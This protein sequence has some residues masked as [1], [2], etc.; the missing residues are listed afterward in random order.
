MSVI[1]LDVDG[2]VINEAKNMNI[3]TVTITQS[4]IEYMQR[5]SCNISRLFNCVES[6][7][8]RGC[9]RF[10]R[11]SLIKKSKFLE[12]LFGIIYSKRGFALKKIFFKKIN[13]NPNKPTVYY[14][15]SSAFWHDELILNLRII[16]E[17]LVKIK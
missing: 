11:F 5:L 8:E 17:S 14:P 1:S 2:K 13:L 15:L 9:S 4:W 3:K 7:N 10:F 12:H 16:R 6:S